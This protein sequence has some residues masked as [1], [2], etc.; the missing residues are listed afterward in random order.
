[1]DLA[2]VWEI[3]LFELQKHPLINQC[4][5][6]KIAGIPFLYVFHKEHLTQNELE[7]QLKASAKI[8]MTG[9]KIT[10]ETT[11]VRNDGIQFVYRH[12]FFVPQEKMFCCGNMCIDCIRLMK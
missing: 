11:F 9:K 12:R 7:K 2:S 3:F 8:A 4:F 10:S 6:K 5:T 1:M